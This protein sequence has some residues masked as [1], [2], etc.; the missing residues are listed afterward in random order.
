ME[1]QIQLS[2]GATGSVDPKG[3]GA[4]DVSV[5]GI[6]RGRQVSVVSSIRYVVL[7]LGLSWAYNGEVLLYTI[8][9]H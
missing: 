6:K 9:K 4:S 7:Y 2:C 5:N 1:T 8:S 3:D